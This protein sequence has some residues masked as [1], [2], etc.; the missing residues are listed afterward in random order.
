MAGQKEFA[1]GG[2]SSSHNRFKNKAKLQVDSEEYDNV[3]SQI[4]KN[5][6]AVSQ[7]NRKKQKK[8]NYLDDED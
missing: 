8:T 7:T 5:A 6:L 4:R 3:A 2:L 1:A